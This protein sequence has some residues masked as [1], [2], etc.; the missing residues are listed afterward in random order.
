MSTTEKTA[1]LAE[2]SAELDTTEPLPVGQQRLKRAREAAAARD[3]SGAAEADAVRTAKAGTWM[4][5]L[6]EGG[7]SILRSTSIFGAPS[8]VL[9]R[10]DEIEIDTAML[11]ADRDRYGR[12]SWSALVN[13]EDA[14]IQKWGF[15]R[16]RAGRAPRDLQPWS[17][18]SALWA[19]K[20]E[21]AR[22]EAWAQPSAEARAEALREVQRVY[23][24][25][26]VTST[27]L[28]TAKTASERAYDEQA[29]RIA[30]SAAKGTPNVGPSRAGA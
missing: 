2:L 4:H 23:G 22:R 24:D 26:P 14:Q 3:A 11:E 21:A 30:A 6:D 10:G 28:N 27:V 12:P 13:D 19:E 18:G 17:R 1:R 15:V 16:L 25:A 29:E 7:I 20:R 9:Y 8:T 5:S